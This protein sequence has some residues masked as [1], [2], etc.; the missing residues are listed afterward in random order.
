[1]QQTVQ[2]AVKRRNMVSKMIVVGNEKAIHE[3]RIKVMREKGYDFGALRTFAG[4]V[5]NLALYSWDRRF[6]DENPVFWAI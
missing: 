4:G 2:F 5:P 3:T 1:M 6:A